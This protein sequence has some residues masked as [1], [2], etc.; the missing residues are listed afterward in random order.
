MYSRQ[1]ENKI[2]APQW[3]QGKKPSTSAPSTLFRL[4]GKFASHP[5]KNISVSASLP[6]EFVPNDV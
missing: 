4:S 6:P 5:L 1:P 3:K 2:Y